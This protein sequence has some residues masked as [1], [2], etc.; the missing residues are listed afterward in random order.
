MPVGPQ[1]LHSQTN[2]PPPASRLD[3]HLANRV[4]GQSLMP[5]ATLPRWSEEPRVFQQVSLSSENPAKIQRAIFI[6]LSPH[7]K[8]TA[9]ERLCGREQ[10]DKLAGEA[11]S[12]PRSNGFPSSHE[13]L[14]DPS[15]EMHQQ[16]KSSTLSHHP[17]WSSKSNK[18]EKSDELPSK[19]MQ[20][21]HWMSVFCIYLY[22]KT[23]RRNR[24]LL[25]MVLYHCTHLGN[26]PL[27]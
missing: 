5:L 4:A 3:Q 26:G 23:F 25:A 19:L 22:L 6:L 14:V 11:R 13:H 2:Q 24:K 9:K 8:Q 7:A 20:T 18:T 16:K 21:S 1:G 15:A 12:Q 27:V 10:F 17:P